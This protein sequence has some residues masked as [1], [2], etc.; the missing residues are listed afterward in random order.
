MKLDIP[1]IH[2]EE[3]APHSRKVI[4]QLLALVE[5]L[6]ERVTALEA[7]VRLLREENA[8]LKKEIAR[9]KKTP[10]NSSLPPSSRHPHARPAQK[11]KKSKRPPG[12]QPGH[13]KHQ[14]PLLPSDECDEIRI[15]KP[16]ECRRCGERL[17]GKDASP[18]LHQVWEMPE[19]KPRVTEYQRHRLTC[20][21]CGEATCGALPSGVSASQAGPR[22]TAFVGLLLGCFR[23]SKSRTALFLERI[24]NQPCSTGWV[25]KLQNQATAAVLPACQELIARLPKQTRLNIDETPAKERAKKAWLWTFVAE[26]FTAFAIRPTRS[27]D[28]LDELLLDDY[29][30]VV[31]CDRAKMY[32]QFPN[33]QWCWAHLKRD[34]QA[35]I[36]G[37]DKAAARWG[38]KL[39]KPTRKLFE[40]FARYRD[41]TLTRRG[42][43]RL[44][45]PLREEIEL[46][47]L[48]GHFS[49]LKSIHG[50]FRDLYNHRRRLWT[51]VECDGVEPTNNAAERSLRHG[52][53]WRKLSFGT[54]SAAGSRF[55]ESILTVIETC[56]QQGRNVFDYLTAAVKNHFAHTPPPSLLPGV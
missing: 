20:A 49:G 2:L 27:R 38:R 22:L 8:A 46:V 7:E 26:K 55:V 18:L 36:D 12:G 28:V 47:L 25:V 33:A 19:I 24:M 34:F 4:V 54:Q 45:S 48:R 21:C 11:K 23:Q 13:E 15:C 52:V 35:L 9:L 51:F 31:G 53:I 37:G 43:K 56:R 32:Y 6:F 16:K 50:M 14:R 30:G 17:S 39:L 40:L 3:H 41:G 42:W 10:D 5:A 44:M 29:R 1:S